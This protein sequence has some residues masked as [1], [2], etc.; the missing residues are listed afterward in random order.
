MKILIQRIVK[1]APDFSV[2]LNS[3]LL[4]LSQLGQ[5][6]DIKPLLETIFIG[7]DDELKAL[8]VFIRE[9][10]YN[11][12]LLVG[13]GGVGKTKLCL[14]FSTTVPKTAEQKQIFFLQHTIDFTT[15]NVPSNSVII[16][17]YAIS[18]TNLSIIID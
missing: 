14:E 10:K 17:D 4:S 11:V 8:E 15:V 7:R 6:S 16:I 18:N 9:D 5:R 13:K 12:L 1:I 3:G 2:R